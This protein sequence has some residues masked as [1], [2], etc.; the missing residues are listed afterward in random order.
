MGSRPG[1]PRRTQLRARTNARAAV[2]MARNARRRGQMGRILLRCCR[3]RPAGAP[4]LRP[5]ARRCRARP[6]LRNRGLTS[7]SSCHWLLL[8]GAALVGTIPV[9]DDP[10]GRL[11]GRPEGTH[12]RR[13]VKTAALRHGAGPQQG[14]CLRIPARRECPI[15][16]LHASGSTWSPG[17]VPGATPCR[18]AAITVGG[19][20]GTRNPRRQ[21]RP[22]CPRL[23]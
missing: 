12:A 4:H 3:P 16:M 1:T 8:R 21:Y 19:Q 13:Q 23:P 22:R 11:G 10:R 2:P 18:I 9:L 7:S 14:S 15:W 6:C 5:A 17:S 20:G